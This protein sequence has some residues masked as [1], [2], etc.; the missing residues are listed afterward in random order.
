MLWT[1]PL[2][3]HFANLVTENTRSWPNEAINILHFFFTSLKRNKYSALL[4]PAN[5]AKMRTFWL[6]LGLYSTV[7]WFIWSISHTFPCDFVVFFIFTVWVH[8]PLYYSV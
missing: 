7:P 4:L 3:F 1:S 8:A 6:S 2:A 5:G